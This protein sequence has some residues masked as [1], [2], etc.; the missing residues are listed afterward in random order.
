MHL[1]MIGAISYGQT[2]PKSKNATLLI[3]ICNTLQSIFGG[4]VIVVK[5]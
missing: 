5:N 1:L 2:N 3:I 4:S